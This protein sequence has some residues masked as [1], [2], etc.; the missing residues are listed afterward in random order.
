[1]NKGRAEQMRSLR[2]FSVFTLM[3]VLA[4][5]IR[6]AAQAPAGQA[7]GARAGGPPP[8][9]FTMT[10]SFPD[11]AQLP[12][13][14]S[15]LGAM[16]SPEINWINVPKGT[17]S[18]VLSMDDNDFSRNKTTEGMLHWFVWNIPGTATGLP[19]GVPMG[20]LAN[21]ASQISASGQMYRAPVG[22]GRVHHYVFWLLALDTKIDVQPGEPFETRAAVLKAAQGHVIGRSTWMTLFGPNDAQPA[23]VPAR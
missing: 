20:A 21:G 2:L 9:P 22:P 15:G 18:F 12:Q 19:E 10:M 11:G 16:L 7:G 6:I 8:A 1:M 4:I 5:A 17:V 3:L 14:N 13:K 23:P